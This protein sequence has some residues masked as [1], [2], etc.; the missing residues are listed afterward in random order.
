MK[1]EESA[2]TYGTASSEC[3]TVMTLVLPVDV[4]LLMVFSYVA[5]LLQAY[6]QDS[7]G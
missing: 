5:R 7:A 6:L 1:S 2:C 3:A 4:Q